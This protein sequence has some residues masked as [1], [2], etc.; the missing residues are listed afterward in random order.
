[1]E[2]VRQFIDIVLHLDRYLN[3]Q[4]GAFGAWSYAIL[5]LVVFCETGL[6]I[7]PFLPGDSL[8][9]ATGALAASEGSP[10]SLPLLLIGLIVAA[11]AGDAVNYQIGLRVGPKVFSSEQSWLFNKKHLL[12]AQA[13]YEKYGGKT[14]VLARFIPIIRTFA[15]FVAGIGRMR[16]T[17]FAAYNVVGGAT[18]VAIFLLAGYYLRNVP[19]VKDNFHIVIAA[20]IFISVLPAVIEVLL[21]R[22]R[23]PAEE[24]SAH[25]TG[26]EDAVAAQ[27]E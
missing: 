13:F 2:T 17:R 20:I 24:A 21:A 27:A 23:R 5:F 16:Y 7:T 14:I 1:M 15:P 25:R 10:L 22:T 26:E 12:R 9:F 11:V 3:D 6:V 8:L 4:V 19:V 18:W